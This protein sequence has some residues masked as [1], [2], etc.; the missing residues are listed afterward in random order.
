[1]LISSIIS[2]LKAYLRYRRSVEVLSRLT[3]RELADIGVSR[4]S[5][6]QIARDTA[7]KA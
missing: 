1:M 4:W 7:A 2:R 5:I 3:D 6:D